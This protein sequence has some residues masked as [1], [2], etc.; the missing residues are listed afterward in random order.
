VSQAT[1]TDGDLGVEQ[2]GALLWLTLRNPSA[3]NALGP[4]MYA[5]A[6]TALELATR[7]ASIRAVV[8]QGDG[9]HFCAGGQLL[10]LQ[11]NRTQ[12]IQA[13][14]DSIDQLHAWIRAMRACPKPIVAA[15]EGSC[16]GAGMSLALACDFI[17]A[18]ADSVWVMAYSNIGLSPDGGASWQLANA[19]PRALATRWLMLAERLSPELLAK[20][21]LVYEVC[22]SGAAA[23]VAQALAERLAE[24]AGN[25]SASIKVLLETAA[26]QDLDALL[27]LEREHFAANLHH[28]N[29]GIG[30]DAFLRKATP[31]FE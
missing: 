27:N 10:R 25:A 1:W 16:A 22:A 30:I 24:R 5:S 20:H 2:R 29:G 14:K 28:A 18:A 11:A 13:Q 8:L 12:P 23:S 19:V 9:A 15:V 26:T 6:A 3:R 17:V 31:K 7:D 21:G 4:A